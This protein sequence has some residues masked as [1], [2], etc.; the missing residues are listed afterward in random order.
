MYLYFQK[1]VILSFHNIVS[2]KDNQKSE[3]AQKT[4]TIVNFDCKDCKLRLFGR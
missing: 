2:I 4:K 3:I 1:T